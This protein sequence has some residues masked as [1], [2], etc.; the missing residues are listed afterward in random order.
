MRLKPIIAATINEQIPA[1]Y[2]HKAAAV[3]NTKLDMPANIVV[4]NETMTPP[5]VN[6]GSPACPHH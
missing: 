5:T 1:G 3:T 6:V 4:P 2:E